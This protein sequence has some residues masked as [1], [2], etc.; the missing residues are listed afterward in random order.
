MSLINEPR[1]TPLGPPLAMPVQAGAAPTADDVVAF[2]ERA[3]RPPRRPQVHRPARDVAA[4]RGRRARARRPDR[5]RRRLRRLLDPRLPGDQRVGHAARARPGDGAHRPVPRVPHAVARLRRPRPDHRR[6]LLARP[7]PRRPQGRAPPRV[8]G[9]RRH[10]V[11]RARRPSS[12]SSTTWPTAS[13]PT[14]ASTRSTR[15]R[16]TGTRALGFGRDGERH[17]REPRLHATAR[18]RAT[19]RRRRWTRSPTCAAG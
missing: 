8:D 15:P 5:R 9:D 4:L 18:S 13:R 1:T 17:A 14:A 7:A 3:R 6:G 2:A 19:S 12:T 11:L 16:A 10:G